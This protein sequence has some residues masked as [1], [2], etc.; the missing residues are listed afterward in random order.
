MAIKHKQKNG[1]KSTAGMRTTAATKESDGQYL[2]KLVTVIILGTF[3]LRFGQPISIGGAT[4]V[5]LPVGM[6]IGLILIHIFERSEEDRKIWYAILLVV[7]IVC[8][9]SPTG[10]MI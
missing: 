3:W 5:A 2:L 9:F 4:L 6:L 10:I 7:T 1:K 8:L